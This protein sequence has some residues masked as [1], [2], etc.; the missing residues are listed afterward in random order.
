M[1][2]DEEEEVNSAAKASELLLDFWTLQTA[3]E[4]CQENLQVHLEI[5]SI[6]LMYWR[7]DWEMNC[8]IWSQ[9]LL[10]MF[11]SWRAWLSS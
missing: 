8:W 2:E 7:R 3:F 6:T 10:H 5:R 1:V 4:G 9:L 11:L